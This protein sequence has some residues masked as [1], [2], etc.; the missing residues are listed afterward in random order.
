M[1]AGTG[2]LRGIVAGVLLVAFT[3]L[4]LWAYSARRRP[5]FEEVAR[6]PLEDDTYQSAAPCC[7]RIA[8]ERVSK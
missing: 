1:L 4:W 6:L 3:A 8:A 7:T 2:V 5:A